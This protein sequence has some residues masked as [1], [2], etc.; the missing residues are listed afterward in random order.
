M[1][2]RWPDVDLTSPA[3]QQA[4]QLVDDA[5]AILDELEASGALKAR[6]MVSFYRANRIG[7]DIQLFEDD[8]RKEPVAT[9]CMLRQQMK[10]PVGRANL[11]LADYVAPVGHADWIGLFAVTAGI[12][13]KPLVAEAEAQNDDYRAIMLKAVAD[14]LAEAF[15]ER[16]HERVRTEFW[17]V[18]AR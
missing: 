6:G 14:R 5:N 10:R 2:G 4:Q 3:G 1:P 9:L 17:G 15:A 18:C 11:S 8:S 16:L 13:L 12:G 7:D